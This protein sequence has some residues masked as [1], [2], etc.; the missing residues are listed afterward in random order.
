[1]ATVTTI[2]RL[3]QNGYEWETLKKML[4]DYQ[5]EFNNDKCFTSFAEEINDIQNLYA[6]KGNVKLIALDDASG[7]IMG[8]IAMQE[9]AP[10][11]TEMKRLYVVPQYRGEKIGKQLVEALIRVATENGYERIWLDTMLEMTAAQK[12]Y[13]RLGFH[14]I[15]PYHDQDTSRM[16]CY[17]KQIN[18]L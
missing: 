9:F 14:M 1:L 15:E 7:E 3:P 4:L 8:C 10:G 12:L 16:I 17:E 6:K 11:I 18:H 2:I 5:A 13:E